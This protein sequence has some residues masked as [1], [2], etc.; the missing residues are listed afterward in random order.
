MTR[1][2]Y[3]VRHTLPRE[4]NLEE[5]ELAVL[6]GPS[7]EQAERIRKKVTQE[8]KDLGLKITIGG[9]LNVVNYLDIVLDLNSRKFSLIITEA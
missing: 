6:E 1:E 3:K 9:N 7:G 4:C 8:F 2:G 5:A